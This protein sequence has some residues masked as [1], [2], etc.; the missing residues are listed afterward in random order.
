[1]NWPRKP[2]RCSFSGGRS[3]GVSERIAFNV[4]PQIDVFMENGYTK[5][6]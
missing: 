1:M 3:R 4:L 5:K 6:K 2:A